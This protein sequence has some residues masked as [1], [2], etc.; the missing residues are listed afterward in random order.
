MNKFGPLMLRKN[1]KLARFWYTLETREVDWL[2]NSFVAFRR[3]I[4]GS[5]RAFAGRVF[6]L[7]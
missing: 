5:G 2:G 6:L 4:A 1:L 7:R 3:G